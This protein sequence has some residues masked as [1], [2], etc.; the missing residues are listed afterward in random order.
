MDN[1][2]FWKTFLWK[3]R[4]RGTEKSECRGYF[5]LSEGRIVAEAETKG[6]VVERQARAVAGFRGQREKP[7]VG[8][9]KA[10]R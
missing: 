2:I 3:S 6:R 9:L 7:P 5:R 10:G 8:L 1:R 4:P